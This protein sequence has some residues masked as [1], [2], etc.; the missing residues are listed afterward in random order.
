MKSLF[1]GICGAAALC[2]Q[3]FPVPAPAVSPFHYAPQASPVPSVAPAPFLDG[4]LIAAQVRANVNIAI[5]G[6][7]RDREE[8]RY[9]DATRHLDKAEWDKAIEAFTAVLEVKGERQD[10]AYYWKA[11]ALGK[12]GR[13]EEAVALLNELEKASPKSRW[14][15]DAKALRI[16]LR[17]AAGQPLSTDIQNDEELKLIALN[18]LVDSS[19]ER[20]IPAL[21][22]LLKK[23]SS[24]R[25]KERALFV[26]AQ[27]GSPQSREIIAMYA[28]GAG[29]PDLQL[30]AVEYLGTQ[31]RENLPLLSEIYAGSTD[32]AIR[33]RVLRA[34]LHAREKDRLLEA[35]K[36]E[37]D[38]DLRREA[39]MFL[40]SMR[41]EMEL[42]QLYSSESKPELRRHILHGLM[43]A[44]SA[45][46]L[47]EIARK[48]T[49]PELK[50]E[51]VQMLS[52]MK[53]KEATDYLMEL[54]SK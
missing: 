37:A 27:S 45:K 20:A 26:L 48:E 50:R 39:I 16:E 38:P 40:G 6:K 22:E 31:G 29:N 11:Y 47:V 49:N 13:R 18:G 8:R 3:P 35:A 51:A 5:S 14:L 7:D 23:S 12:V 44:Q 1:V 42:Q 9:R 10:G 19:P 53:S 32:S 21:R 17:Q 46:G 25:L 4:R 33:R 28:K 24:P 36:G 41:A 43:A 34:Y 52:N 2:A 30:K 15:D 54:I